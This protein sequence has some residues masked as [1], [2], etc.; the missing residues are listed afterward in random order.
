MALNAMTEPF[1]A[2]MMKL[3]NSVLASE[4]PLMW[5]EKM[6]MKN[7]LKNRFQ[8]S[9][10]P[11]AALQYVQCTESFKPQKNDNPNTVRTLAISLCKLLVGNIYFKG[12][13]DLPPYCAIA[14]WEG[15]VS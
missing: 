8:D 1:R 15:C 12:V 5:L 4:G 14:A 7:S 10:E 11:I 2:S 13:F 9:S 6:V 3:P